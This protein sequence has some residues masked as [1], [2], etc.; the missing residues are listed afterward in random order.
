MKPD[1]LNLTLSAL[2]DPTRRAI[3][4]RLA[5]GEA[6]VNDLV[7]RFDMSQPS[8]SRHLKVLEHAGL[9]SRG[10]SAQFRP[11]RLEAAPLKKVAA[12][13]DEYRRYWED[14]FDRLDTYLHEVQSTQKKGKRNARK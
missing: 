5:R 2:A 4:A 3:L 9:I 12:W 13:V 6:S 11:C 14:S 8:I 1:P 7:A 10:R